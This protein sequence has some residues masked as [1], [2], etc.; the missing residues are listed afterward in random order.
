[1]L[2]PRTL[3]RRPGI[4]AE[5][6]EA[7]TGKEPATCAFDTAVPLTELVLLGNIAIRTGQLLE[8]DGA[9]MRFTNSDA[10]NRYLKEDYRSGWTLEG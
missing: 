2:I 9:G 6:F 4:W 10:A 8:W 7:C 1:M 3:P 5:W